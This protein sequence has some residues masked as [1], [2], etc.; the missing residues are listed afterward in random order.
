[1]PVAED[2]QLTLVVA[3][4]EEPSEKFAVAVNCRVPPTDTDAGVGVTLMETRMPATTVSVAVPVIPSNSAV[5][6]VVPVDTV[7]G[8]PV[9]API[10]ATDGV[11]EDHVDSVVT[12]AVVP[13]E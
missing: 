9:L 10:V 6:V 8:S 2:S 13:S 3:S 1:M 12:S 5:I 7:V 4:Q 11:D